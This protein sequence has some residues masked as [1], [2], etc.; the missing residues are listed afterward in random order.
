MSVVMCD[1]VTFTALLAH[2]AFV[3]IKGHSSKLQT[4]VVP[5]LELD[6]P[7]E[8][9]GVDLVSV[10]PHGPR[11]AVV[12][13][14]LSSATQARLG[15]GRAEVRIV[16]AD[17]TVHARALDMLDG[18]WR[19]VDLPAGMTWHGEIWAG[20][21]RI[22]VG[23]PTRLPPEG[24]SEVSSPRVVAV[25]PAEPMA[26]WP[27]DLRVVAHDLPPAQVGALP[28]WAAPAATPAQP[29]PTSSRG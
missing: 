24:V 11:T 16:G 29:L 26:D 28:A 22:L 13:W 9:Y 17:G 3:G 1:G 5:P 27:A 2:V 14:S 4:I 20:N 18:M 19:L 21:Q 15:A 23:A 12:L 6:D 7:P 8:S 25:D 10:L